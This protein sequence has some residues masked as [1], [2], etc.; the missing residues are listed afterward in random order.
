MS[1]YIGDFEPKQRIAFPFNTRQANGVPTDQVQAVGGGTA[2]WQVLRV[3]DDVLFD[4]TSSVTLSSGQP[5]E[6]VGLHKFDVD[7]DQSFFTKEQNYALIAN[8][9]E[10]FDGSSFRNVV[11][12]VL[13]HFSLVYRT[14]GFVLTRSHKIFSGT[15]T[16]VVDDRTFRITGD[17]INVT[18][19]D[20]YLAEQLVFQEPSVNQTISRVIVA[21]DP[22]IQQ[23]IVDEP[24]IVLPVIGDPFDLL[25]GQPLPLFTANIVLRA[26][27][28]TLGT[29]DAISVEWHRN[30]EVID[31][32]E[33][34]VEI[35]TMTLAV[36]SITY[37]SNVPTT[38][39]IETITDQ[40]IDQKT[41][42]FQFALASQQ[43]PV[44][45]G[46]RME[47]SATLVSTQ[48][49]ISDSRVMFVSALS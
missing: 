39:L 3:E 25:H 43:T 41:G 38:T 10:I 27:S 2:T 8:N 45:D 16:Q 17:G 48:R 30:A 14:G 42:S 1:I 44:G 35:P 12:T 49:P 46:L 15:I 33:V 13:H 19:K 22:V 36:Y 37:P 31:K 29:T 21:Y 23:I 40:P 4:A 11:G 18:N 28:P 6:K 7:S 24:F 5:G 9:V 20:F 47:C 32:T 26:G 34:I